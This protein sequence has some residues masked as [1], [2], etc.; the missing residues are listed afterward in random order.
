M[1]Q[2]GGHRAFV[3]HLA[4]GVVVHFIALRLA[5]WQTVDTVNAGTTIWT[6][7]DHQHP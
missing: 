2:F 7:L 4:F 1:P 6:G 5:T 3:G